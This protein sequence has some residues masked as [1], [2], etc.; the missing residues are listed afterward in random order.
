MVGD[1]VQDS[2]AC[3]SK[4]S[5]DVGCIGIMPELAAN[6]GHVFY[7]LMTGFFVGYLSPYK[8]SLRRAKSHISYT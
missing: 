7:D 4:A 6:G 5:V 8:T 2:M 3:H 1:L